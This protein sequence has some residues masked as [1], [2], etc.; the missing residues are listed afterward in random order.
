ME[1]GEGKAPPV[2]GRADPHRKRLRRRV[3]QSTA[4]SNLDKDNT[5]KEQRHKSKSWLVEGGNAARDVLL[6]PVA[7]ASDEA[8]CQ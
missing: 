6:L 2:S 7:P 1:A 8:W 4:L 3:K 5:L